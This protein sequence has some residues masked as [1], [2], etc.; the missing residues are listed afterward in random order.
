VAQSG[1][2]SALG[3]GWLSIPCWPNRMHLY[4]RFACQ[5][6]GRA[7]HSGGATRAQ[8]VREAG[9]EKSVV[10]RVAGDPTDIYHLLRK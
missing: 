6:K 10:K 5:R 8:D 4:A 3:N 7:G 9:L 2:A 1:S